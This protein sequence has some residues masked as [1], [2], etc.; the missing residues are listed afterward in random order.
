MTDY[1]TWSDD[2]L[3]CKAFTRVTFGAQPLEKWGIYFTNPKYISD[4]SLCEKAFS[5]WLISLLDYLKSAVSFQ[6]MCMEM[7]RRGLDV[8]SLL[9]IGTDLNDHYKKILSL[10]DQAEQFFLGYIRDHNVHA[11]ISLWE[12][13]EPRRRWYNSSSQ[14]V[15][16]PNIPIEQYRKITNPLWE[17]MPHTITTLLDR[18]LNSDE[19]IDFFN[20]SIAELKNDNLIK[21]GRNI[22][23]TI[24]DHR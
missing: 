21:L 19:F 2:T 18:L 10:F 20:F 14:T 11:A 17:K 15:E 9:K 13:T 3:K 16:E 4:T 8:N 22:G 23:V 12:Q 24:N 7:Q 1:T 6:E 5:L